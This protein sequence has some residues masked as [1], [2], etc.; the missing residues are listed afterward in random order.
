M[1]GQ[2]HEMAEIYAATS[3][4]LDPETRTIAAT[5][6]VSARLRAQD[7]AGYRTAC[8]R[9]LA[10][11]RFTL[12]R[13]LEMALLLNLAAAPDALADRS[14][15]TDI[16]EQ[17]VAR[18]P[19]SEDISGAAG[20]V[21][22]RAG[23]LARAAELLRGASPTF[24]LQLAATERLCLAMTEWRMGERDKAS[25][26]LGEAQRLTQEYLEATQDFAGNEGAWACRT[27]L[28]ALSAEA[29]ALIRGSAAA[30]R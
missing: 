3:T 14:Q 24:G 25:A 29:D 28:E 4:H 1:R 9:M 11:L 8:E 6:E 12:D 15:L 13:D 26:D 19:G 2:W 5:S 16:A 23:N 30:S 17:A 20:C 18:F 7:P 22:M 27:R 10:M 21:F